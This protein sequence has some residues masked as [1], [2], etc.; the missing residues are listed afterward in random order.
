MPR[1]HWLLACLVPALVSLPAGASEKPPEEYVKAMRSIDA[2]AKGLE[3]AIHDAD[4]AAM[5]KYVIVAR[6]ALGVVEKYWAEKE[7][8]EA[9]ELALAASKAIS[10]ISVAQYL[11]T[12]GPNPLAKEGA[13]MALRDLSATCGACH[14]A[15]REA[16]PDGT[17]RIK[18]EP[19]T[20]APSPSR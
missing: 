18:Y 6:S 16:L 9:I 10:E 11:L 2:A 5:D 3:K 7:V 13:E 19:R 1:R 4:S 8:E 20:P 12:L 15:H 17:Y 14:Q